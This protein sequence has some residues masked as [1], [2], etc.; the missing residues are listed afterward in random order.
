MGVEA[1]QNKRRFQNVPH[2]WLGTS[3]HPI[4]LEVTVAEQ[5]AL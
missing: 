1:G 5:A 4:M 3:A 2:L